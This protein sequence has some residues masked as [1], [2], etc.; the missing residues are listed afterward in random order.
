MLAGIEAS[1]TSPTV[2][3][4]SG[5][6]ASCAPTVTASRSPIRPGTH[7][8]RRRTSGARTSTPAVAPAD[9][10]MPRDPAMPGSSSTSASTATARA[11]R[12][13][14]TTPRTPASSTTAAI[15]E[16]RS[17]LGSQRV[18]TANQTRP[19]A[20]TTRRTRWPARNAAVTTSSPATTR[21][22]FDP[23]TATRCVSP[24]SRIASSTSCGS[25]DVSPVTRPDASPAWGAGS[26]RSAARRTRRRTVS[27]R[28][29]GTVGGARRS[30]DRGLIRTAVYRCRR[31]E[32]NPSSSSGAAVTVPAQRLPTTGR[33]RPSPRSS[34]RSRVRTSPTC[35]TRTTVHQPD[36]DAR[37]SSATTA[38]TWRAPPFA[39]SAASGPPSRSA[40]RT[41]PTPVATAATAIVVSTIR[42]RARRAPAA[43]TAITAPQ[44]ADPHATAAPRAATGPDSQA[45]ATVA[46]SAQSATGPTALGA[47]PDVTRSPARPA[48]GTCARRSRGPPAA[49]R[50]R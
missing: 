34:A 50:P 46:T 21:A 15:A 41:A 13:S 26:A 49:H 36:R 23:L 7:P 45:A 18:R 42:A 4:S 17:T 11:W 24:V 29:N 5:A 9:R 28:P 35:S 37:G 40:A 14:P 31:Y 12:G 16:A 22:T 1:G 48:T 44:P 2:H 47:D 39:A 43:K 32:P 3:S 25:R 27:V 38:S 10:S 30:H 6:T 19:A 20:R 33:S 8:R